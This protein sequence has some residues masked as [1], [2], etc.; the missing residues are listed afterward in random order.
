MNTTILTCSNLKKS[1]GNDS[2]KTEIIHGIALELKKGIF[3]SIIGK[4]GCGKTTLLYLVS[5]LLKPDEGEVW[6]DGK[7]LAQ[8]KEE[9]LEEIRR[10]KIGFVFQ[11]YQ[12]LPELTVKENIL[13]PQ[14]LDNRIPQE[15]WTNQILKNLG[16]YSLAD[17]FPYELSGGEQQRTAIGRAIVN[18]PDIIFADEPTGN[19]DNRTSEEVLDFL[20]S[21]HREYHPTILMVT[22]DLDL[23]RSAEA[24]FHMEDGRIVD[25][26]KAGEER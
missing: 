13:L 12:L 16:L 24:V 6:L 8:R 20:L 1:Y 2:R 25:S 5:G 14:I 19:L 18:R 9:E 22:H 21:V 11:D 17:K 4:S 7:N 3:Y 23:A 10:N 26:A 15:E